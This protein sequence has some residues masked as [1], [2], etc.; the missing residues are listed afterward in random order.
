MGRI[1]DFFENL[2]DPFIPADG[3]PPTT[4]YAFGKWLFAG[5]GV[6]VKLMSVVSTLVGL[7]EVAAA[8]FIGLIVERI[9]SHGRD[10]FFDDFTWQLIAITGFFL[11]ARPFAQIFLGG[12][13]SLTFVP[14]L[15]VSGYFKLHQYT[16][17]QSLSFFE[18]DFAGRINQK[19]MQTT[20]A[21]FN[22]LLELLNAVAFACAMLIGGAIVMFIADIRL[23]LVMLVWLGLYALAMRW[24]IP[25]LRR[26]EALRAEARSAIAGN[27]VDSISNNST[28]KLF[29]HT[30]REVD[31]ARK[32]LMNYRRT[33]LDMGRVVFVFRIMI[34]FLGAI[35]PVSLVGAALALW[36][37]GAAETG[38]IV[39]AA[40]ITTRLGAMTSWFS[41]ALMDMFGNVGVIDDGIT[42]LAKKYTLV[43]APDAKPPTAVEGRIHF[44]NV[45][46]RYGRENGGGLD[47]FNL[48]IKAGEKVA[49]VGRSGAGKSTVL[50]LL[51]R[52]RDVEG[53]AIR[54]DG[55]DIRALTQDGL[56]QQ[57]GMVTQD[58]QMFNRS[59]RANIMYGRPDAS[60]ADLIAACEQA[61]AMEFIAELE[62]NHG[63]K[64]FDARLGERGVKLSG[65]QRQR[66]ALA[67]VILKNAPI[68]ALDEATS[69]LD[70]EVEAAIQGTLDTL[71]QGKT[72]IAIAHRLSTIA[73][74]DRIVVVD[75]GRIVEEGTHADLLAKNGLYAQFWNRQSG[76]FIKTLNVDS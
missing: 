75:Q 3:P 19:Q 23:S 57:I 21:L 29:A 36:W 7:S 22:L 60:E 41:F 39:T 50:S 71:M 56:R 10:V 27:F 26:L 43:D 20:N 28:V 33:A 52:L 42:T 47:G 12:L 32:T 48:D 74:M 31:E 53:G 59:A 64:G 45:R 65:G 5:T 30:T 54:L 16:L 38:A 58:T 24:G 66:I 49:L 8:W 6:A 9:S 72:V 46:F 37:V 63:H 11:V 13:N 40:L 69:A 44:D 61:Q 51:M 73:Q 17:G 25:R 35:L 68:L 15:S 76:G 14:A 62:D 70:S 1:N 55:T 2:I 34:A 4:L 67:R 18:D